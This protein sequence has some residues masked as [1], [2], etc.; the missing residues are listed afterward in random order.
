[1]KG[2]K[3]H[4]S[5][6]ALVAALTA[7]ERRGLLSADVKAALVARVEAGV[8]AHNTAARAVNAL[9]HNAAG[10]ASRAPG[11]PSVHRLCA[12]VRAAAE[13][14]RRVVAEAEARALD[15]RSVRAATSYTRWEVEDRLNRERFG[16][17]AAR[18]IQDRP[19]WASE[20]PGED[21]DDNASPR[22]GSTTGPIT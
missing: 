7:E 6:A 13:D 11:L 18:Q 2:K 19:P 4:T 21:G 20:H 9:A 14:H 22:G 5:Q 1:L 17:G 15:W 8:A 10:S 3:T 16:Q 12:S